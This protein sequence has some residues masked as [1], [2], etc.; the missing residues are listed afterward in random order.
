M[1]TTREARR[2]GTSTLPRLTAWMDVLHQRGPSLPQQK[3]AGVVFSHVLGTTLL[4]PRCLLFPGLGNRGVHLP[5]LS[6]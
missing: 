1:E 3:M 2:R 5:A 6:V 4:L